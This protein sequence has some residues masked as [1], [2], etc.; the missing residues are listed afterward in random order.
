[1]TS[2]PGSAEPVRIDRGAVSP[3]EDHALAEGAAFVPAEIAVVEVT[4]PGAVACVQGL[5]TNDLERPGDGAFVYGA[6]LSPKGMIVCDMWVAR[7]AGTVTLVLPEQGRSALEGIMAR[8]FPPRL[9]RPADRS[10]TL[11]VYRLVGPRALELARAASLAIPENG[12]VLTAIVGGT[13]CLTARPTQTAP[14]ALQ[15]HVERAHAHQLVERLARAGMIPG[16][17][18]GLELARIIAGWPRLGVEID[19]RTLP[20]EVR[21]DVL[22]GVSYTK[23]CYVG[24]E[25]VARLHFRGHAN[26]ELVGLQWDTAPDP[27]DHRL[28]QDERERGWVTS[29]AW[30]E[31]AARYVGLAKVR[32]EVDRARPVMAGGVPARVVELP[33]A[34]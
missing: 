15:V 16:S 24:Q 17:A 2:V 1:M 20:Q 27:A 23:G 10:T 18:H 14:F 19:D 3:E 13:T 21:Y 25:T 7:Q 30:L 29:I 28:V 9:A 34:F 31:S 32:R 22:E 11:E 5:L 33:F 4:G 6:V 12:R 8:S 26:R